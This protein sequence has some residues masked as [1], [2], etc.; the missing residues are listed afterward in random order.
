MAVCSDCVRER[1]C[2]GAKTPAPLCSACRSRR[3][4][5]PVAACSGCGRER[6]CLGA[7]RDTPVCT[8]R[9]A[10]R[11]PQWVPPTRECVVCKRQRPCVHASG[12]Q[13]MCRSCA[14]RHP[15]RHQPC[16]FCGELRPITARSSA[17]P[18]CGS[19]RRR[20]MH[21]KITC[22]R[23]QQ[24]A[25]PSGSQPGFCGPCAGE[26]VAHICGECGARERN[27]TAGRCAA[28][29]L[30]ARVQELIKGGAPVAVTALSGYLTALATSPK[31]A[32]T[33]NWMTSGA[34]Q[35]RGFRIL[36][37]L[38][39]GE[40]PLTHEALD[41][42]DR[43]TADHLRAHL[44]RHGALPQRPQRATELAR[45]ID[46]EVRRVPDGPDRMH[47]RTFAIW[48][49]HHDLA[50][51]ERQQKASR[52][53]DLG[54]RAR[55]RVAAD[56]LLWLAERDLTLATLEQEHLDWWLVDG[57][58]YRRHVRAFIVWTVKHKITGPLTVIPPATRRH[59]APLDPDR[60]RVLLR[61]LLTDEQ[62]DLR[63]RVAGLLVVVF[64]QRISRL[65]LLTIDDVHHSDGQ[66]QLAIGR[67]PLLLPEP[68]ATLLQLTH[69]TDSTWRIHGGRGGN[70]L[71]ETYMRERLTRLGIKALRARTAANRQLATHLPAAILAGLL[72]F[73]GQT[74]ERWTRLAASDWI[75]YAAHRADPT[76]PAMRGAGDPHSP[77]ALRAPAS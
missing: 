59:A 58:S 74:T 13:P 40:L 5:L 53:A 20:R 68:L 25:R 55:V 1:P 72:G 16:A 52:H 6:P 62:I 69:Q 49:V 42:L 57:T 26:R 19:C 34:N 67:D 41:A 51:K 12:D 29:S 28:C 21:A 39:S 56:L 54:P 43:P 4:T 33:L 45:L 8:T 15:S 36:A 27:H 47:L 61:S 65:V 2:R 14:N 24:T 7:K 46:R 48:K 50:R 37:R 18:E 44:V 77:V 31:P 76:T 10:K 30:K 35:S 71:S 22:Q 3:C 70:H 63:D 64:P 23:C 9:E 66:V 73:A 60:R 38:I 75:R 11:R 17:G 32:S